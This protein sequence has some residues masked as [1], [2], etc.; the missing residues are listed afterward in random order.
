VKRRSL[1]AAL[2]KDNHVGTRQLPLLLLSAGAGLVCGLGR[3]PW[4]GRLPC[5]G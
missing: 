4:P 3:W 1:S 2:H 5:P